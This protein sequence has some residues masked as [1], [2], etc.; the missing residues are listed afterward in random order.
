M[1]GKPASDADAKAARRSPQGVGG[2]VS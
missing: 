2:P 1:A